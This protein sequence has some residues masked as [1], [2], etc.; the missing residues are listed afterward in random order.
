MSPITTRPTQENG[1]PLLRDAVRATVRKP[2]RGRF[3]GDQLNGT[4]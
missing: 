4:C 3:N 1:A 2:L